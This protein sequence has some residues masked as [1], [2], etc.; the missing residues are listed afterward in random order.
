MA[1]SRLVVLDGG[2]PPD[3]ASALRSHGT[4]ASMPAP[5]LARSPLACTPTAP[6]PRPRWPRPRLAPPPTLQ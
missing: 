4:P 6:P 5:M 2:L 1:R 3:L